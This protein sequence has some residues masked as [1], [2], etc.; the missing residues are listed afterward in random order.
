LHIVHDL[1]DAF[2]QAA[3][4]ATPCVAVNTILKLDENS[5]EEDIWVAASVPGTLYMGGVDT[6][7]AI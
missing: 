7:S 4:T 5:T 3:G 6:V 1:E 2:I